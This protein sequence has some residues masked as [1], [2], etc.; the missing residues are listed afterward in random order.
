MWSCECTGKPNLT[1][2]EAQDSE[3]SVRKSLESMPVP[4]KRSTLTLVHHTCRSKIQT[5]TDQIF[6]YLKNHYQINEK[7]EVKLKDV[8]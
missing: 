1:Y 3:E 5:L 8:W 2:K 6:E 4:L 7:V